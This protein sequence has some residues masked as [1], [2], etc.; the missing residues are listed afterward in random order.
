MT[1]IK[2]ALVA[3][4][5]AHIRAQD[6]EL[7]RLRDALAALVGNYDDDG[8]FVFDGKFV[9]GYRDWFPDN[10][11]QE[12]CTYCDYEWE[13]GQPE[14]HAPNCPIA[15]ARRALEGGA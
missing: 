6:A 9:V 11:G 5:L 12:G 15:A 13:T 1:A 14:R 8:R 3:A 10:M 2:M 7:A 4:L